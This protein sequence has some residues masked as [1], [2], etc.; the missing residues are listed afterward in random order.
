[1]P[2]LLLI[3][4]YWKESHR[5][6]VSSV[7]LAELWQRLGFRMVVVCMGERTGKEVISSTLTIYRKKDFFLPDPWNYGIAL[8]FS[9]YVRKIIA[10]EKPDAIVMN[11]ILFWSSLCMISLRLRGKRV[12]LLTDALVG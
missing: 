7:K 4:P 12:I 8:G 1:M 6:M 9:G 10:E 5:W 3:S 2:T 11:K